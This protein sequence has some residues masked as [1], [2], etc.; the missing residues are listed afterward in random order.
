MSG[1]IIR[2]NDLPLENSPVS[3]ENIAIDG[4]TTRRTT[5]QKVVDAGAPVAS[6]AEAEAG[7]NAVKRMTPLTT[8]Q[9]ITAQGN[10]LFASTAQGSLANTALQPSS[11]GVTVGNMIKSTYDPTNKQAD[12]FLFSNMSG[13]QT[14][15][16]N[17]GAG[18][19]MPLRA[20]IAATAA[21]YTG[22]NGEV[23]VIPATGDA[24]VH[25]GST[26][27]GNPI[28]IGAINAAT[29]STNLALTVGTGGQ[30]ATINAAIIALTKYIARLYS[31]GGLTA[32]ITLLTGFV[33]SEQVLTRG[34]DLSWITIKSVDAVVMVDPAAITQSLPEITSND[35][36]QP[37]FGAVASA[38]L[39]RIGVQFEYQTQQT[40]TKTGVVVFGGSTV[41]FLPGS[42]V[43][44]GARGL[45]V[46]SG[47][48]AYCTIPGYRSVDSVLPG[49]YSVDFSYTYGRGLD[50][51]HEG[52]AT[53]PRSKFNYCANS[54]DVSV[55]GIWGSF[56][57][58]TQSQVR[59]SGTGG[60]AGAAVRIRDGSYLCMREGDISYSGAH[61]IYASHAAVVDFRQKPGDG[62]T[63]S[64]GAINCVLSAI[65]A[66]GGCIIEAGE[67]VATGCN[68]GGGDG[69]LTAN[70]G[71]IITAALANVSN[72]GNQG[73][74]AR[75]GSIINAQQAVAN[76]CAGSAVYTLWNGQ[77]NFANGS[78]INNGDI[79]LYAEQ[80][81]VIEAT[82]VVVT[83]Y[84]TEGV[85][86]RRGARV[87]IRSGNMRKTIGVDSATDIV[88]AQG[89][90]IDATGVLGG[91]SKPVNTITGDG[92]IFG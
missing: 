25:D 69:A 11:I 87:T 60:S 34:L 62:A 44:K 55:Y 67:I 61:G 40:G 73:F 26:M 43:R 7:S 77:V 75:C 10:S 30:Y 48:H 81:G 58:L 82:T 78:A 5:I 14:F 41:E 46:Y 65:Y 32:E 8:S 29:M 52:R 92:I 3:T 19:Q 20:D 42:G 70:G 59:Y 27:G 71:S 51:Q 12:A 9:A 53:L 50:V 63:L 45:M 83:G 54:N 15:L 36:G 72:S 88:C 86:A 2:I 17:I 68:S 4:G 56:I 91:F 57:D 79:A 35:G 85:R 49:V 47:S 31:Q 1:S 33:M 16:G 89:A 38:R 18:R 23:I 21:T 24:R 39:P 6:Q 64:D 74:H 76:G 22:L 37:I 80:G 13:Q 28:G 66:D 84:H 90:I